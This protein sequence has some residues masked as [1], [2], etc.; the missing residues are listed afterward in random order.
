MKLR[1]IDIIELL[2]AV[3]SGRLQR[4]T[5]E[6]WA[7]RRLDLLDDGR[8]VFEPPEDEQRLY[9]AIAYL[10]TIALRHDDGALVRS[11][12]DVLSYRARFGT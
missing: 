4:D 10:Q 12:G 1:S 8:L 3:I 5:V 7:Q 6:E 2:D 9:E 11:R